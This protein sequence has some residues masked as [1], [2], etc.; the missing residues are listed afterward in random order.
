M[1][2]SVDKPAHAALDDQETVP[3]QRGAAVSFGRAI[4][5]GALMIAVLVGAYVA[6][7]Q[8]IAAAPERSARPPV[9][10]SLPVDAVTVALAD[11]RPM[12]DLYGEVTSARTVEVRPPVSGE[13]VAVSANLSA[14]SRVEEGEVLFEIDPFDVEMA[15]AEARADLA[16]TNA[17]IAENQARL[18][19]EGSQ[20]DIARQQLLLAQTD[21]ERA[22]QLR[23]GGT[24]TDKQVE[25][26]Q[27]IVS[28]REQAVD[29]RQN[30]ITIE[31][32]R[33]D[34]QIAVRDRLELAVSR[35]ERNL[36][37]ATVRAPF[38][39][40]VRSSTVEIGRIV[41]A[42][43]VA[44]AMYD[45]T[46]LDVRFT[47][48][49]AQ[50]GR[51]ATD[52]DPLIGRP[53]DLQWTVGNIAYDYTGTVAR[54]GADIASDRGGIDVYARI[55]SSEAPVQLRPGAF[56][57]V[58]V[59]DRL[60]PASARIPETALFDTSTVYVIEHGMLMRRAVT[61]AAFDGADIIITDG[62]AAGEQ[63]LATRLSS[64]EDGLEVT[65][66]NGPGESTPAAPGSPVAGQVPATDGG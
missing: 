55:D 3:P 12:V 35:A 8:L 4:V 28:Q 41:A 40:V 37:D 44:V 34:Q 29:Q 43:D 23:D 11:Q 20:L 42:N 22:S 18:A 26:R 60:Y 50:Y 65:I 45:D 48:T 17:A 49:D 19:S 9:S 32:A 46:A 62:V 7:E 51:I 54:I 27:L 66:V 15:L 13:V 14:G 56:M 2:K 30:N 33:L 1:L 36:N 58:T 5:Q 16:Q 47:L 53:V 63:V 6:M 25:E 61:V 59:P 24:L 57:E 52:T 64:V 31:Q 10:V 38:S 21:L 39:G